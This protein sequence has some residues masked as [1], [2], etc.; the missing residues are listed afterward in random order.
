MDR[1]EPASHDGARSGGFRPGTARSK[2][3]DDSFDSVDGRS[4]QPNRCAKPT[5][6]Q[7]RPFWSASRRHR[8]WRWRVGRDWR[9]ALVAAAVAAG[10]GR[11][12][13]DIATAEHWYLWGL[14]IACASN[15]YLGPD[16]GE[17]R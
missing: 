10:L 8:E 2:A 13:R 11:E 12:S 16:P 15:F 3:T 9:H 14:A 4:D 6:E 7:R 17:S 1:D 5:Y